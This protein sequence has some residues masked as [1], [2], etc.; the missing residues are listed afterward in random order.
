M[1][2]YMFYL[3]NNTYK[4]ISSLDLRYTAL[5]RELSFNSK[6]IVRLKD[7]AASFDERESATAKRK[8]RKVAESIMRLRAR[9]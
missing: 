5:L 9:P 6:E 7:Q 1:N 8:L 4:E 3:P 2:K